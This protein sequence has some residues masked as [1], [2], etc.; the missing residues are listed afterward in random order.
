MMHNGIFKARDGSK[1]CMREIFVHIGVWQRWAWRHA[2]CRQ[3]CVHRVAKPEYSRPVSILILHC[4][5][6]D[7]VMCIS[8]TVS[9]CR[10]VA[11]CRGNSLVLLIR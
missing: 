5:V 11:C 8:S 10:R 6:T 3:A 2:L 4:D 7:V 1:L 9:Q